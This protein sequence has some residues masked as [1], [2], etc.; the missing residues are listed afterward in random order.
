MRLVGTASL[1]VSLLLEPNKPLPIVTGNETMFLKNDVPIDV[2]GFKLD[3]CFGL[4]NVLGF[5]III[6]QTILKLQILVDRLLHYHLQ[7]LMVD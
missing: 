4:L 1:D 6:V 2:G 5:T 3:T 7:L